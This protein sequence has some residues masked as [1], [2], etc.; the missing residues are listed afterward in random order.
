MVPDSYI[1][2]TCGAEVTVGGECP[3]CAPVKKPRRKK[4]AAGQKKPWEQDEMYDGLDLPDDEFDY[5][6]FV[7][8][9]LKRAPHRKIGIRLYHWITALVLV[10]LL[11]LMA[12][13]GVFG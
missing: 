8:K 2:P 5:D 4:V 7:S 6:E 11:L 13:G 9:E 10:V 1:C 12:L 3:G